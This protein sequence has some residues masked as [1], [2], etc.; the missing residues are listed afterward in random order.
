ME[1]RGPTA[2]EIA[3][4]GRDIYDRDIRR[5]VEQ[6]HDG[7]ILVVDITTGDY[8]MG[9]DDDEVFDRLETRNP[10]GLFYLM[11]VGRRAAHRIGAHPRLPS[12]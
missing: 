11:R 4:R 8:A 2:K 12:A 3:R 7:E 1:E 5:R 9:E 6:E 10:A